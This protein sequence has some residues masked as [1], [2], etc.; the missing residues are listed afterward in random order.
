MIKW[1][2]EIKKIKDLIVHP[3]NPRVLTK[4]QNKQLKESIAKF[5][6]ADKP[7]INTDNTIIGGHQRLKVMK[8]LG[9]REVECWVPEILLTEKQVEEMNVRLNKNIG[10]FDWDILA[11]EF[12]VEDLLLWG[13][14]EDELVGALNVTEEEEQ[15]QKK[16]KKMTTCPACGHEF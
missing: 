3:K 4:E 16:K 12:E 15:Q 1:R 11:N 10:S 7:I 8:E 14:S 5:G 13:F 6:L 9:E 2:I